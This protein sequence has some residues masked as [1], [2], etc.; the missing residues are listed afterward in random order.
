M[1]LPGGTR[2]ELPRKKSRVAGIEPPVRQLHNKS[3][4]LVVDDD[5]LVRLMLKLGLERNGFNVW[6]ASNGRD[7]IDLYREHS[8]DISMV[9]LDVCMPGLNGPQTLDALRELNSDVPA[10]FMSGD[11][12]ACEPR[13]LLERRAA[14][15]FPKPFHLDQLANILRLLAQGAPVDLLPFAVV[16]QK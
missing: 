8:S 13:D 15:V 2:L 16:C 6:L 4:I 5:H 11:P 10:C 9:L 7:A 1:K 3:G 12:D 14:C